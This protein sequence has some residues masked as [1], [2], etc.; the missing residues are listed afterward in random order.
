MAKAVNLS[1]S[2]HNSTYAYIILLSVDAE[3]RPDKG[4]AFFSFSLLS[5]NKLYSRNI[6]DFV[7]PRNS[8]AVIWYNSRSY[9]YDNNNAHTVYIHESPGTAVCGYYFSSSIITVIGFYSGTYCMY[10][11]LAERSG[12][13]FGSFLIKWAIF[14]SPEICV[15][16]F[17]YSIYL[18]YPYV[19]KLPGIR[20][21]TRCCLNYR[22]TII[23]L[24]MVY[25]NKNMKI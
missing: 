15:H 19:S 14:G 6:R 7:F 9:K 3:A 24:R 5:T 20:H 4:P 10:N 16:L 11:I 17:F 18:K 8:V 12:R 2:I 1:L 23:I 13:T 22:W 21:A 25:I